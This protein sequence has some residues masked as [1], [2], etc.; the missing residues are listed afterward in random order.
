LLPEAEMRVLRPFLIAAATTA[1][2]GSV[3]AGSPPSQAATS[4]VRLTGLE[5]AARLVVDDNGVTHISAGS[6]HDLFLLNGWVQARDRLFQ[7]DLNRRSP[8]G[9]VA[10]LLGRSA[11]PADV[12]ART[13]GL[14]RAAERTWTA[15]PPELRGILQAYADGVNGY[16]GSHPLP[17][18][19]AALGVGQF[20]P[21]TPVDSLT[22]GKAISFQ[23]SFDLDISLT[24]QLASYQARYGPVDG[25][26]LFSQDVMRSQPFSGA[27]T[28]PDATASGE[29]RASSAHRVDVAGLDASARLG[30]A[31]LA[32]VAGDPRF[33]QAVHRDGTQGSN[34]W[35]VAGSHTTTGQPLVANDPHLSLGSP[36]TFYPIGL[37]AEGMNVEGEGFAGAPGVIIGH[38]QWIS[39]GA[40]TNPMDV[41]DTF[42]EKVVADPTSP[43]KLA[44]VYKGAN[45][46][47]IPIPETFR[48]NDGGT[49]KT[50]TG[51][52]NVP[53]ATLIV[54][55]R[56]QG[57]IIQLDV[58][59]GR[60]LSVQYTGFSPT[61]ELQTFLLWDQAKNLGDFENGL[62][63]FDV[64]SQNWAYA[65]VQGNVAYFTSAE[66]PVREDL[67]QGRV[68]GVPPWLIRNGQ[69]G[70]EW[71]PVQHPQVHQ[72]LPYEI[73]PPSEMPHTVN[74]S[75]G[76]FVNANN[77]PVGT[78][79]DN[80]PLNQL[81]PGGGIYYLSPGYDGFRAGRITE[82]LRHR[83]AGGQKVSMADMQQMQADTT[84]LDAEYFVPHIVHAFQDAQSS[85]VSDLAAL[86]ND[87]AVQEAVGRLAGWNFTTPT[88]L[89]EGYDARYSGPPTQAEVDDSVAATIY[90]LWRS[91]AV[92][93][94]IDTPLSPL[95]LPDGAEAVTAIKHLLET[96]ETS[97]GVGASGV[98]FFNVPGISDP[99]A[100]RDYLLLHSLRAGLNLLAG[101][102]F[103]AAFHGST[104]QSTYR[105]G[106]LHRI[107]FA[108]VLGGPF[109][110][111]PAFGRFPAPLAGLSGIPV[112][113]GFET[114]DAASHNV[115]GSSVNG[116]MFGSGPA[117]R[118]ISQPE[119][120]HNIAVSALPG[121]T[122]AD[123]ESAFYLNLLKPYLHNEY[124]PA[125]LAAEV[126]PGDT[127][128]TTL[129][130]PGSP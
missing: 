122:S 93:E 79:L 66:M 68:D 76:W 12:N 67:Q 16:V 121:G 85:D 89:Q 42:L 8:S 119:P 61:F 4:P 105:W 92:A 84:L 74:P 45:E 69:G 98:D 24:V 33:D 129:L 81:R 7:M 59:Q 40:T 23:L 22:V 36:S 26:R 73:Y 107:V 65:D 63:Y 54:P 108:H 25:T 27:S 34:E 77:D 106:L 11:L 127:S 115:R 112:D 6:L 120:G 31:Y 46:P 29:L 35:A 104:D 75:A 70:N 2:A 82:M 128:S 52:D 95:P 1:L 116:F 118:F 71:L 41:T 125:L 51:A 102:S 57:P 53:A 38:N 14:R 110:T 90:A 20:S 96:F 28:V 9:T 50:A 91:R 100:A 10:E 109:S 97:H 37:K 13:I 47:V 103:D 15:A 88:G 44:T 87:A 83:L 86:A 32:K 94:I 30:R 19:Y 113:G 3:L 80:D 123:P 114:V 78:T 101:P 130:T 64:G 56:N 39:W 117:R 48:Y 126:G 58:A 62:S 72:A 18:E 55:R 17:V 43:S 99:A 21:W 5:H 124:Y 111:P 49:L 60:A